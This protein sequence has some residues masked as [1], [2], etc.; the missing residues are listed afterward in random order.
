[1][2]SNY[3]PSILSLVKESGLS[4][5]TVSGNEVLL[6][7][8]TGFPG[9][10]IFLNGNGKAE[11]ELKLAMQHSVHINVDSIRSGNM[12]KFKGTPISPNINTY[13]KAPNVAL[14]IEICVQI[15]VFNFFQFLAGL[16][17]RQVQEIHTHI[18]QKS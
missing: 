18:R 8:Q 10:R 17:R 1:M 11:W 6:A 13:D 9:E 3:N 2:K 12:D 5:V 16:G 4:V 15:D 14:D 7:L